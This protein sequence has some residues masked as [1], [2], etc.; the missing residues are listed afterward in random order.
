MPR[1]MDKHTRL[2]RAS[3]INDVILLKTD[4]ELFPNLYPPRPYYHLK[5]TYFMQSSVP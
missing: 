3:S 4:H 5:V 2:P 1:L